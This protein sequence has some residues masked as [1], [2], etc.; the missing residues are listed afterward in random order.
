L[1]N[2]AVTSQKEIP[3]VGWYTVFSPNGDL[4]ATAGATP[5]YVWRVADGTL[6]KTFVPDQGSSPAF[7]PNGQLVAAGLG[8]AEE[9]KMYVWQLSDGALVGAFTNYQGGISL[10]GAPVF[11]PDSA[12]IAALTGPYGGTE[13]WSIASGSLRGLTPEETESPGLSVNVKLLVFTPDGRIAIMSDR[14]DKIRIWRLNEGQAIVRLA[15]YDVET[16]GI[17]ALAM[18]PKGD[19]FAFGRLDGKVV[20]ARVP[21]FITEAAP[22][23]NEFILRWAGGSGS[24]QLQQRTSLSSGDWENSGVPTTA[25]GFTNST[26]S[27]TVFYRVQSMPN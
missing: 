6:L 4:F 23:G 5:L 2:G 8:L 9:Y 7:S 12:N 24:Y 27:G 1:S 17:N 19:L 25:T 3:G 16:A 10:Y 18:S 11:S 21:L 15:L 20:V 13:I 22:Q 14:D 26:P